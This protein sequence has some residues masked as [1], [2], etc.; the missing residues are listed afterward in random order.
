M[1]IAKRA[2]CRARF[3]SQPNWPRRVLNC[4]KQEG[5]LE[6]DCHEHYRIKAKEDEREEVAFNEHLTCYVIGAE[7]VQADDETP[8]ATVLRELGWSEVTNISLLHI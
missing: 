8:F 5:V 1:E 7:V 3:L 2:D 6:T 4:L